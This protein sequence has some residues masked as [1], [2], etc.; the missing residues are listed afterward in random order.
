MSNFRFQQYTLLGSGRV[1]RH[2]NFYLKSLRLPFVTWSRASS[3]EALPAAIEHSSHVLIA[4]SDSAIEDL[5]APLRG[6]GRVLV[7]FSGALT[8]AGAFAAHPLMTFGP[9]L[10]DE[11]WYRQIPFVIDPGA[12]FSSLLPG[13]PNRSVVLSP[14]LRCMYHALCSLA[15]N[16][17]HLLWSKIGA[18]FAHLGL[19]PDL[20]RPYLHQVVD[21]SLALGTSTFTGPVARGDWSVVRGHLRSLAQRAD[22]LDAYQ[23]FLRMARASGVAVPKE[24]L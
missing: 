10:H 8:V 5:V 22:L 19:S 6:S 16:S 24:V 9:E 15:G 21:D 17:T 13:F 18:E 4:V 12:D 14:E 1:A 11:K 20:L 7:H 2:L 23:G 3:A